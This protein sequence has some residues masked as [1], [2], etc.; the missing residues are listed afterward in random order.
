MDLYERCHCLSVS[1][2]STLLGHLPASLLPKEIL[3]GALGVREV[4]R[5]VQQVHSIPRIYCA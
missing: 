4:S 1:N 3:E 2:H 5:R